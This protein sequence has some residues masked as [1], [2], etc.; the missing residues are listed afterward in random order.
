MLLHSDV[1][2]GIFHEKKADISQIGERKCTF[3]NVNYF[4]GRVKGNRAYFK[5][6]LFG[7]T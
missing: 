4:L 2:H 1:T 7:K 6:E 5:M 3:S